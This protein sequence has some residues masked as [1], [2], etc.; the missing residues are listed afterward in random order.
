M[1]ELLHQQQNQ[2]SGDPKLDIL[3]Q[4]DLIID[5]KLGKDFPLS[6]RTKIAQIQFKL[7]A[8]KESLVIKQSA[9]SLSHDQLLQ[10]QR[11]LVDQAG[12]DM[13]QILTHDE[14]EILFDIENDKP[15]SDVFIPPH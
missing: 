12:K 13:A 9:D 15:L 5:Q 14:Y 4:F 7:L 8:D 6:K 2:P 11:V 3:Q 10:A 1:Y